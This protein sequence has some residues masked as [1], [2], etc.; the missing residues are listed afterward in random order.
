[1]VAFIF[2]YVSSLHPGVV[3]TELVRE[4]LENKI[5][6]LLFKLV[7]PIYTIFTKSSLEG[8]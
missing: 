5:I 6:G 2:K 4:I 8:A 1:M 3:R 7:W